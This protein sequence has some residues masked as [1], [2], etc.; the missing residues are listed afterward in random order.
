[1]AKNLAKNSLI[2]YSVPLK[3]WKMTNRAALPAVLLVVAAAVGCAAGCT[4]ENGTDYYGNDLKPGGDPVVVKSASECCTVC[5]ATQMCSFWTF[6]EPTTCYLK[7]SDAGRHPMSGAISGTMKGPGPAP[8]P[9]PAPPPSPLEGMD[10]EVHK[11]ALKF[12]QEI[13]PE[14]D[15]S[16]VALGLQVDTTNPN[17][18]TC[19]FAPVPPPQPPAPPPPPPPPQPAPGACTAIVAGIN[20][21][22]GLGVG[23]YLLSLSLFLSRFD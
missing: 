2:N 15:L 6:F 14:R 9:P 11:L 16:T 22:S 10:C 5:A 18:W 7:N 3:G 1:M 8:P 20:L 23:E 12:A 21:V 17:N 19:T 4:F 13:Q